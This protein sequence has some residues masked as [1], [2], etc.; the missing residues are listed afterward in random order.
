M[1]VRKHCAGWQ[2]AIALAAGQWGCASEEKLAAPK[3]ESPPI[4]RNVVP[5][6]DLPRPTT[7]WWRELSSVE[8]DRLQ[9]VALANNRDLQMAIARVAQANAQARVAQAARSP[10]VEAFGGRETR[11]PIDGPGSAATQADW[12]SQNVYRLGL[13]ASYEVDLWGRQGYAAESALAL[14]RA[15]VHQRETV[16]LTLTAD[17]A[18]AYL[19]VL[20]LDARIAINERSLQN[21]RKSLEGL[22]KRMNLG[23]GTALEVAQQRVV[24]ANAESTTPTLLQR[25][26]RAFN[27]LAVLAGVAPTELKPE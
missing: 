25:R 3:I 7:D 21:R 23:D 14:A 20:S 13:R 11:A 1:A 5:A 4:Y 9:E 8:L 24:I 6:P 18:A 27:R 12:H 26:E 15:S 17:V 22:T 19:E 2:I 16:A 10:T